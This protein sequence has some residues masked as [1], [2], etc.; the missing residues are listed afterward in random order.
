MTQRR[1][2]KS[3]RKVADDELVRASG[4]SALA[5]SLSSRLLA[6][7]VGLY[8]T[9][10]RDQPELVGSGVLVSLAKARFL[11]TAGHVLDLRL[12]GQLVVGVSP[13]LVSVSGDVTR[14]FPI[15]VHPHAED[16][17]DLGI[18]RLEGG[19]WGALSP[20]SFASWEELDI[21]PPIM[22]RHT[23]ALVGFPHSKNR[24]PISGDRM[25]AM[26]YRMAGLESFE[27]S[28]LETGRNPEANLM[29]DF[30]QKGM[31][32][33]DGLRT[34]PDLYGASGSGLWRFGR[35]LRDAKHSPQLSAIAIE[36]HKKGRHKYVLGTRLHIAIAALS[37]RYQDI[38][39]FV[40]DRLN[41]PP[42]DALSQ[43]SR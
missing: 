41:A 18:V 37:E 12:R 10:K 17:I 11:F 31:W 8:Q 30:D 13:E 22:A 34:S 7:T 33:A 38:R 35:R 2:R 19:P 5:D 40:E 20:A 15:G 39:V 23:F 16:H 36:W 21:R 9:D 29:I 32:G 25:I 4:L 42:N 28:Y 14:L 24:R 1:P 26:A 6:V 43:R 3:V 27:D